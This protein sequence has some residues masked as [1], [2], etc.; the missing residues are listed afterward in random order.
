VYAVNKAYRCR[1]HQ[2]FGFCCSVGCGIL[3]VHVK[4]IGYW[5]VAIVLVE[6]GVLLFCLS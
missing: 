5:P 1:W 2:L 6:D 3:E 4:E